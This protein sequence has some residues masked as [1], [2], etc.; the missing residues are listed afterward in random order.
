MSMVLQR[1]LKFWKSVVHLKGDSAL[2]AYSALSQV[3]D[4]PTSDKRKT[5][6][7]F[8]GIR[9]ALL[10]V[11]SIVTGFAFLPFLWCI[12]AIWFFPE[13]FKRPEYEEQKPIKKY[14]ILSAI[15]AII[16]TIIL[17]SWI[18]MFQTHRAEWGATADYMSF[19][20][21]TGVP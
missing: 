9:S 17:V 4:I 2:N 10:L 16:W 21:P 20:I 1:T 7:K 5:W 3:F 11:D 13:A 12:N 6:K 8:G 18:V 15:G 14:V 19:I